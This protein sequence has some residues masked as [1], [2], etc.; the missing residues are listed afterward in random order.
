MYQIALNK[1]LLHPHRYTRFLK[2]FL[3]TAE[4]YFFVGFRVTY[5]VCTDHQDEIP[6]VGV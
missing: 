6:K 4:K 2:A 3:E 5:Y 1:V